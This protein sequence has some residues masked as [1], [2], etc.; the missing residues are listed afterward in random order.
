MTQDPNPSPAPVDG[1]ASPADVSVETQTKTPLPASAVTT[2]KG[3]SRGLIIL[4]TIII[5][6]VLPA[7]VLMGLYPR[8]DG[9]LKG[10]QMISTLVY[11][12][13]SLMWVLFGALGFYRITIIKDHP[14]LKLTATARLAAMVL[15]MVLLGVATAVLINL[16]PAL[17]LEVVSPGSDLTAPV[18][19]TFGMTTP[20][21]IFQQQKLSPLK[22]D[23][24]FV[25]G[26]VFQQQTF[27]PQATFLY[28][29]AG[30]YRVT[31][32]VTMTSGVTKKVSMN[33]IIP[34]SSFAVQPATPVIDEP[35]TFSIEHFFPKTADPVAPKLATGKWDFDGD[36]VVDL[37]S[38]KL[39]VSNVYRRLGPADVSVTMIMSNQTQQ[40]LKRKIEISEPPKQPFP[41]TL[42]TEPQTLLGPPP[43]GVLFVLKTKE[44]Q[45]AAKWDFGNQKSGEGLRVAQV[46]TAVGNY[47]VS[48]IVRSKS[49][50]I[51]KLSKIVRVTN[52]L[53][54]RDLVFEGKPP[55]KDFTINGEVPLTI[56]LTPVTSMPLVSFSWDAPDATEVLSTE[57]NFHAVYRD[58]GKY[59]VD[60]IGVDPDQNVFRR[61]ITVNAEAARSFVSFSMDPPTP[62]AP[63]RVIFDASDTFV[64]AGEEIT[65]F[66]WDFGDDSSSDK[67]RYSGSRIEHRFERE[68]TYV[69]NL[70]VRTTSGKEYVGRQTLVVRAPL[71]DA[72]FMPSRRSGKAPLGVRFDVSCSSGEFV[73]WLWNFGDDSESDQKEPTHVYM[74][75][76]E[77]TV[78]MT[79]LTEDGIKSVKTTTISISNE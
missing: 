67:T 18:T 51:A 47:T 3:M 45:P 19:V 43:F 10:L 66:I 63:A 7:F 75:E 13:G 52:P 17:S 49:G 58:E 55:V 2:K 72:C 44:I 33:L 54:I 41:I 5:L 68:G 22:Y 26:G 21:K 37:E 35:V 50:A 71:V 12:L 29:S 59:F 20:L 76:G 38:D 8:V 6:F 64:P 32:K 1:V 61:R 56:D 39:S 48:V 34:N 27:E 65:G 11:G 23:W 74:T 77:F 60:L 14:R 30:I 79:A 25:G 9:S 73:S 53:D 57:K 69:I 24:D 78:T 4:I 46:Y 62:M 70:T 40:V 16:P 31:A 15:P 42:E 28:L 36:S